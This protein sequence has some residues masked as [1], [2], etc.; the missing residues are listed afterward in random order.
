MNRCLPFCVLLAFGCGGKAPPLAPPEPPV[1]TVEHPVERELE[2]YFEFTGYLKAARELEVRA[3]VTGYLKAIKF[4]DGQIVRPGD[5]LYE[6]DPEPYE[7]ALLNARANLASAEAT[8]KRGDADNMTARERQSLAKLEFDRQEKLRL[9]GSASQQEYDKAKSELTAATSSLQA[10][11]AG[12]DAA[13]AARDAAA[14]GLR[15]AEFDRNNCTIRLN[16]SDITAPENVA[17][18]T[19]AEKIQGRI[20]RTQITEGNLVASGQTVLCRV[21][22]L[23]PMY[24]YWDLDEMTSLAYRK[25]IYDDKTLPDPRLHSLKCWIGGKTDTGYPVEGYVNYVSPEIARGTATREVRGVFPNLDQRLSPGDSIRVKADAGPPMKKI[26]VPEIAVGVRQQQKFVYVVVKKDGQ[27]V[28]EFRPI[29][30][31]PVRVVNGVRLQV[32]E[33]GLTP[34]DTVVVNGLIRVRAGAAVA[35]TEQ[36]SPVAPK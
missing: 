33:A 5:V 36:S 30:T 25:L 29:V 3:Q 32:V 28:A 11:V 15:K 12:R 24:G 4:K 6:I 14:A 34:A 18:K 8:L 10:A 1:V 7:A 26:T 13:A 9:Q 27:H 20:S 16:V 35:P 31:G 23:S 22:S 2:T 19:P 21:V 17:L